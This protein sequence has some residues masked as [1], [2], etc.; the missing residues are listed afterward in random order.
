MP[1]AR[2]F[3]VT[4]EFADAAPF[5]GNSQSSR[6]LI[7]RDIYLVESNDKS[8]RSF[9]L[10]EGN[11]PEYSLSVEETT[12]LDHLLGQIVARA[13]WNA[14]AGFDG[15][16]FELTLLGAKSSMTFRWWMDV[17]DVWVGVGEVF[18]YVLKLADESHGERK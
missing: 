18:D 10:Q 8:S 14:S 12:H 4:I 2:L 11:A 6:M 3:V 5:A 7:S 17:P 16:D 13:P 9:T 1:I 15:T